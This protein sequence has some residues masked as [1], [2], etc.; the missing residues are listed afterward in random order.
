[1]TVTVKQET[2]IQEYLEN[3]GNKTAAY[4]VAYNVENTKEN[5][6]NVKAC[7]LFK[8]GNVAV[9]LLELQ[10][11]HQKRHNVTIDSLTKELDE[12]RDVAKEEAQPAAM[13]G[14][15]MGKAK[16]HGLITDKK[17]LGGIAGKPIQVSDV[18]FVGITKD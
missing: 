18:T 1:M 4:K 15:T 13:T 9:R 17:E 14:A 10:Q 2:F 7:E 3:G 16:L 6:I 8:N 12:A 5:V 11:E